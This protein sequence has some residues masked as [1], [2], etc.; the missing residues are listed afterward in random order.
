MAM[1][2]A[3]A[4]SY[5]TDEE[6]TQ[7][8]VLVGSHNCNVDTVL[9]EMLVA[10][11][12][13]GKMDKRQGY[14]F[15][16]SFKKQEVRP[17]TAMEITQ[18]FVERYFGD[19]FQCLYATHDN[20]EHVHSHILFNSVSWRTGKKYRYEKGDWAREIQPIVNELCKEYGLSIQDIEIGAEEKPLKKWDKTKQGIFKWNRQISLDVN[21]SISFANSYE[22]F[23]K[24]MEL[25]GYEVKRKNG[26]TFLKPMG[27]KR[28]ICM[29][30]ISSYYT[31]ESIE[32]QITKGFRRESNRGEN[33]TPRII[34]CRKNYR[35][36][37]PPTSYQKAFLAK[38][39]R[40]GQLKRKPYSQMWRYRDEAAKFE[41]LQS[42]YLYLCKHSI[43]SVEEF[44]NRKKDIS[45]R[46]DILDE[47]RHQIYK[48]RY[49]YKPTLALLKIIE[50]NEIRA[51]YYKEG[52]LFYASNYEKWKEAVEILARKGYTVSQITEVKK[53]FQRELASAANLK[54]QLRKEE[55]L[56]NDILSGSSRV[57][58]VEKIMPMLEAKENTKVADSMQNEISMEKKV[59]RKGGDAERAELVTA[60]I[61][62]YIDTDYLKNQPVH[63]EKQKQPEQA[64]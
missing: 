51:S 36:Y 38:M 40:T 20:T 55:N 32:N 50:E 15:I 64:R 60:E 18:K 30:D 28:F 56:I 62:A 3:N 6:K 16:I 57:Q 14:H 61:P 4:I 22:N 24:L 17:E 63:N 49:P 12:K 39:Y 9:Q 45:I 41:K 58:V 54:R 29:T 48:R 33:R 52:S 7:R 23:L 31:R 13:Y 21:D 11:R 44:K 19:D 47:Q 8:G 59:L 53:A 26:E 34:R 37:I 2:L 10:K 1:H 5:I 25:K 27:E 35:K 42:Q 46:M 43:Q